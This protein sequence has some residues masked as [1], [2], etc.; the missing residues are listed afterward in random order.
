[1]LTLWNTYSFFVLY[2]NI[3]NYNPLAENGKTVPSTLDL[4]IIS[5]LNKLVADVDSALDTYNPTEAGR[6]LEGFVDDLSNWY[7]RRSRRRFW[8][9]ENDT[10]KL[11]AYATLYECLVTLTKL[12]APFIPFMAE[13]LYQNL[14]RS[15]DK[16]A[17]V[18]VHLATFPVGDKTKV[19]ENLSADTKLAIRLSSLGRAARSRAQVKVR[20]PLASVQ[21][22]LLSGSEKS[23][24][25][26]VKSQIVDELNVKDIDVIGDTGEA[27]S[28]GY[29]IESD[30]G[31]SVVV[32]PDISPELLKEGLAREIVHR[33]QNMRKEAGF[34]IADHIIYYYDGGEYVVQVIT[35]YE[36]YI[37][38]E[39]LSDEIRKGVP[40]EEVQSG[41]YKI[42]GYEVK[43]AVARVNR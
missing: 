36:D 17:P 28:R 6:R 7:V 9:S 14:V 16:N 21:V 18:S 43:L 30:G 23:S 35:G 27:E 34:E 22:K 26:R 10:D 2:A 32:N 25:E 11:S 8:K 29:V 39:T 37:K 15:V 12:V 4:W 31:Y 42:N 38:H 5:E 1:M 19:D 33:L 41:S 24:L 3:D 20:Q 13:E 40:E